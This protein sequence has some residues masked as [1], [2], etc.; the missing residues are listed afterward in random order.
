M[1]R[2]PMRRKAPL[3]LILA[4]TLT[5][6]VL[7]ATVTH[8]VLARRAILTLDDGSQ[9]EVELREVPTGATGRFV[10]DDGTEYIVGVAEDDAGRAVSVDVGGD[11]ARSI[12]IGISDD[13]NVTFARRPAP[14]FESKAAD[15][16][17][18][19]ATDEDD[20]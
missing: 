3:T 14:G 1:F 8:Q 4:A 15:P 18:Q 19:E 20:G 6:S 5:S 17:A 7:A 10:A 2:A 13:P 16:E 9:F 11:P 12:A